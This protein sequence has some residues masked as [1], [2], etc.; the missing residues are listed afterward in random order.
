[1]LNDM[2]S[3]KVYS[4][5]LLRNFQIEAKGVKDGSIL[6]ETFLY[7]WETYL[8]S[9]FVHMQDKIEFPHMCRYI[10][11]CRNSSCTCWKK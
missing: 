1:M 8:E 11:M 3:I 9:Y 5:V 6:F 10:Y 4:K 2:Y 7:V